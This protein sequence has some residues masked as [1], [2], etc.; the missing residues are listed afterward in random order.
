MAAVRKLVFLNRLAP[1]AGQR[2]A[3]L[4]EAALIAVAFDQEVHLVFQDDG[5]FQLTAEGMGEE[6]A[7]E[8]AEMDHVWVEK[9][10]LAARGV[11]AE[12]LLIEAK[13]ATRGR[14]KKLVAGM[15]AVFAA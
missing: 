15:N 14:L 13:V 2:P 4:L 12:D 8:L 9:E 1:M 7:E 10:S 3:E 6:A 11:K 5:V